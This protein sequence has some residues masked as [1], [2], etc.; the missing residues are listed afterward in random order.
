M[1]DKIITELLDEDSEYESPNDIDELK[2]FKNI[3]FFK[4]PIGFIYDD[5]INILDD[6]DDSC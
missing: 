4:D 5:D 3:N 1:E 2:Y 6:S